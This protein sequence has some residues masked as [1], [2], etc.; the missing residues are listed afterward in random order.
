MNTKIISILKE[1][2]RTTNLQIAQNLNVS[3]GTI[4]NRIK[5]MLEDGIIRSFTIRTNNPS[6]LCMIETD[7]NTKTS[8]ILDEMGKIK[9]I[10]EIFEVSGKDSIICKIEAE[11]LSEINDVVEQIR[12]IKGVVNTQTNTILN[13]R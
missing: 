10:N 11:K 9:N 7:A 5:S 8:N 4:R 2:S 13:E 12:E 6:A 1:N 3:E